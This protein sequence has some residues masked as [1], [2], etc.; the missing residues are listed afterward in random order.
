MMMRRKNAFAS[1]DRGRKSGEGKA[2]EADRM[3]ILSNTRTH[4]RRDH[5]EEFQ[6]LSVAAFVIA[7]RFFVG[8]RDSP[9]WDCRMGQECVAEGE[10]EGGQMMI[11][12]H[13]SSETAGRRE[14]RW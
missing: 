1:D 7:E 11:G 10:R 2:N 9:G 4:V 5:R 13:Q 6:L 8:N 12:V 14:K 3:L